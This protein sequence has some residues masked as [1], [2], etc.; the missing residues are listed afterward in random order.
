MIKK[1]PLVETIVKIWCQYAHIVEWLDD[2]MINQYVVKIIRTI[3][4]ATVFAIR[5]DDRLVFPLLL[6]SA[7]Q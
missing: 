1:R 2:G 5:V 7:Q 4:V 3:Q 6:R